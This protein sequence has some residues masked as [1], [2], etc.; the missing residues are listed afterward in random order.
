[1]FSG[2][3]RVVA[4]GTG[5]V[6]GCVVLEVARARGSFGTWEVERDSANLWGDAGS[7]P[8]VDSQGVERSGCSVNVNDVGAD[9]LIAW[10]A[11]A[12]TGS[13][14]AV[15]LFVVV[16]TALASSLTRLLGRHVPIGRRGG[17]GAAA[18]ACG[19]IFVRRRG[20]G[21]RCRSLCDG[22]LGRRVCWS[23]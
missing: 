4:R 9:G 15:A 5:S 14:A 3:R 18:R 12:F 20:W 13:G 11:R 16:T 21:R 17:P 23:R 22:C 19:R 7:R 10:A 2:A 1:M 6:G 8:R